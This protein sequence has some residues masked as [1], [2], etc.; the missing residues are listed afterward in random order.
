MAAAK[1][2]QESF[3]MGVNDQFCKQKDLP[4]RFLYEDSLEVAQ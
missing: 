2:P 4:C 3:K 1:R